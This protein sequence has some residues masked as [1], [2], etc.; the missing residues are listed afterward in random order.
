MKIT[1]KA[2][3]KYRDYIGNKRELEIS[4][5]ETMY[6]ILNRLSRQHKGFGDLIFNQDG[7]VKKGVIILVNGRNIIHL[8]KLNTRPDHDGV[9]AI[10]PPSGGG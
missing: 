9:I 10:F 8:D 1:I 2:F 3:A 6:T 5:G 4:P 7:E